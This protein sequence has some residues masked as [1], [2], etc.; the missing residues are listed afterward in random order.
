M[1]CNDFLYFSIYFYADFFVATSR[2]MH[3]QARKKIILNKS[4]ESESRVLS[5]GLFR[6]LTWIIQSLGS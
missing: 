2:E 4:R 6:T 5:G 1:V 3:E